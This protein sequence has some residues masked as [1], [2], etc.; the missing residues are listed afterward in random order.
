MDPWS[1]DNK[2]ETRGQWGSQLA[3]WFLPVQEMQEMPVRFKG[4]EDLLEETT[5]TT[6]VFLPRKWAEQPSGLQST[7]LPRTRH[8]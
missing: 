4:W 2:G 8:D 6:P 7:G 5:A 1:E 3:Q